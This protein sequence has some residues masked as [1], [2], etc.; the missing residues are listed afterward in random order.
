MGLVSLA[1]AQIKPADN[2]YTGGIQ[3]YLRAQALNDSLDNFARVMPEFLRRESDFMFDMNLF[4][5][6]LY[7]MHLYGVK[8]KTLEIKDRSFKIVQGKK[9]PRAV[10]EIKNAHVKGHLTGGF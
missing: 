6:F 3:A 8:L 9:E 10:M 1:S 2:P 5:G 7:D 4:N